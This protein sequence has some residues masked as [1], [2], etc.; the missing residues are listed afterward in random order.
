MLVILSDLHLTDKTAAVNVHPTAFSEV[1]V[2]EIIANAKSKNAQE[3]RIV[4]LGDNFDLVRTK[5][6]MNISRDER[7]W[8][9]T[10]GKTNAMNINPIIEEHYKK[11]LNDILNTESALALLLCLSDIK[12][13]AKTELNREIYVKISIVIGNHD[14]AFNNYSSLKDILKSRITNVDE[15][16]FLNVLSA[17][18]YKVLARHGHEWDED[19][20]GYDLYTKVLQKHAD[21]DRFSPEVYK[22]QT[23]G[24]VITSELMSGLIYRVEQYGA[25]GIIIKQ[26]MDV[27]NI[28]PMTDVFQWLDWNGRNYNDNVKSIIMISLKESLKEVLNTELA[29]LWDDTKDDFIFWGD[30]TDK[31]QKLSTLLEKASFNDLKRDVKIFETLSNLFPSRH[32]DLTE[33]AKKEFE[34]PTNNDYSYILYGH[35]HEALQDCFLTT[36]EDKQKLYINTGTYLPLIQKASQKG[37]F[38]SYQM[39]LSF[40]YRSDEDIKDKKTGTVSLD[41]WNGMKIKNYNY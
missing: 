9:G 31:L 33:G 20:H 27:N 13:K 35:T 21:V 6:W 38:N 8:N 36:P 16:E 11:I 22:V 39:L 5:A 18:E 23:I 40:F 3:I 17:P 29:K 28:R 34:Y 19:N 30:L 10:L 32:D 15:V 37:F 7:P 12:E 41:I 14:R 4:L 24:E 1:L 2:P 26:L 25:S